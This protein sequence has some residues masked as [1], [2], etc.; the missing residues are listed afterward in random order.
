MLYSHSYLLCE[1][2]YVTAHFFPSWQV[3]NALSNY[4]YVFHVKPLALCSRNKWEKKVNL[5]I[6]NAGQGH[7]LMNGVKW[8]VLDKNDDKS[9]RNRHV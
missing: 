4:A 1:L 8:L 6:F 7:N 9:Y 5:T 2:E 3:S